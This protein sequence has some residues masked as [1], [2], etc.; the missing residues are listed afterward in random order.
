MSDSILKEIVAAAPN[1]R[2]FLKVIGAATAAVGALGV[3]TPSAE[4]QSSTEMDV[5]NFALNL[6]YLEAEF[7]T[8]G[9]YGYGIE[10]FGIKTTGVASGNN[11]SSGG[12]TTGGKQVTLSNSLVFTGPITAEIGV[13]ERAHVVLLQ[14]FLGGAAIAKPNI[15][16][17]ALNMGF[18][19]ENEYL[20]LA[21]IFE[22][23]GVSAYGGAAHLLTTP[24]VIQTA[25][26]ILGTESQHVGTPPHPDRSPQH[27]L[28]CA[29]WRRPRSAPHRPTE[30][31]P[32]H[33]PFQRSSRHTVG[34]PS[35]QPGVRGSGPDPG[36][37]LPP[38]ASM[39]RSP[40]RPA[41]PRLPPPTSPP[42]L[43]ASHNWLSIGHNRKG[44]PVDQTDVPFLC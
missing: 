3:I 5:L 6:E 39:A 14:S 22:D 19:S 40:G 25:A 38:T 26:R 44:A 2:K 12:V 27:S 10:H 36:R 16:L 15:N 28:A 18:G 20:T 13:D 7:Y 30:S 29:G 17:D 8:Y 24:I 9:Q 23:I 21:R 35:T 32:L 31:V 42:N 41:P 43:R 1:R 11:P 34:R 33:Q 4:A 37:I